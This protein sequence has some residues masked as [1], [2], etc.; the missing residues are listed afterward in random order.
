MMS[1]LSFNVVDNSN[2]Y[3]CIS[4][5]WLHLQVLKAWSLSGEARETSQSVSHQIPG[6]ENME[7]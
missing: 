5:G 3:D 1:Y 4:E 7:G 6:K 2:Q